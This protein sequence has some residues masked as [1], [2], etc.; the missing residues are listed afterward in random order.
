MTDHKYLRDAAGNFETSKPYGIRTVA[1]VNWVR[2][3]HSNQSINQRLNVGSIFTYQQNEHGDRGML[4]CVL[5]VNVSGYLLI[6]ER[7]EYE[8]SEA[9]QF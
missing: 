6:A 4:A 1:Y 7:N 3:K 9:M 2:F 5:L 8:Q